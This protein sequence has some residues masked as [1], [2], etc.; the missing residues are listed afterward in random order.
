MK[1]VKNYMLAALT[2]LCVA[3]A[4]QVLAAPQ[5]A[6]SLIYV[7]GYA[8]QEAVPDIAA[9]SL[10]MENTAGNLEQAQINNATVMNKLKIA[11]VGLGISKEDIKTTNY[12]VMP[13]Y[14]KNGEKIVGYIVTNDLKVKVKDL[15]LL[16]KL[17]QQAEI[18]GVN[19]V[20]N[21]EFSCSNTANLKAELI[22]AAVANGSLVAQSA[23]GAAGA[24]LG[25]VKEIR[26]NGRFPS[27]NVAG[28]ENMRLMKANMVDAQPALEPGKQKL[29]ESVEMVFFIE[30]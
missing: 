6:P 20:S 8:E 28:V 11:L 9:V 19:N 22:K 24:Q 21:V 15:S 16:P 5:Q 17:L 18:A 23:A 4:Q 25:K 7:T 1:N 3:N 12:R 14:D 30:E 29:S 10:G 2:M 27:F 13:R 26:I